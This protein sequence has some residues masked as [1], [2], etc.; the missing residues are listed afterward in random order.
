MR[1]RVNN[2]YLRQTQALIRH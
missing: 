1:V 2:V